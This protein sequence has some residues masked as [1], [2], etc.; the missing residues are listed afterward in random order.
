MVS[1]YGKF[2]SSRRCAEPRSI[3]RE[4]DG[5]NSDETANVKTFRPV[6]QEAMADATFCTAKVVASNTPFRSRAT[7]GQDGLFAASCYRLR[8]RSINEPSVQEGL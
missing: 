8:C 7:P 2:A 4:P 6:S 5:I 1:V 3:R